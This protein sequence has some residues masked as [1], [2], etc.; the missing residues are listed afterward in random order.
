MARLYAADSSTRLFM[1]SHS[2]Y[3]RQLELYTK[4]AG[5]AESVTFPALLKQMTGIEP[6]SPAWEAG[7]LPMNYICIRYE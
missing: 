2:T 5:N 1:A 3:A 7:V 6:A 4:K